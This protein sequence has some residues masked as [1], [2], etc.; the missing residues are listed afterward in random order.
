MKPSEQAGVLARC[1]ITSSKLLLY[2]RIY[3]YIY[4]GDKKI[5]LKSFY[6]GEVGN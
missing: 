6:C 2:R 4:R 5:L 1:I 3:I